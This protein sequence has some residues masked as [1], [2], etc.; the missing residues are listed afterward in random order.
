LAAVIVE[1]TKLGLTESRRIQLAAE[2]AEFT[3]IAIWRWWTAL[4]RKL[5]EIPTAAVSR[6]HVGPALSEEL[7]VPGIGRA[8]WRV[9]L[10]RCKGGK[11]S[12]WLLAACDAERRLALPS[13][14]EARRN[15]LVVGAVA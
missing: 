13:G 10:V 7:P 14:Q 8:R 9:D 6:W 15:C 1:G 4:E 11:P 3:A 2:E 5:T 12:S